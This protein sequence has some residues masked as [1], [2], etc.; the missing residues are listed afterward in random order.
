MNKP[1]SVGVTGG[2]GSG[3]T[4]VVKLFE[5]KGIS[6]YIA[7]E[8]AKK[9]ML[10]DEEL[11]QS[12]KDKFG[13]K[14]YSDGKLNKKY[15]SNIVFGDDEKL[16][17]LNNLVHPVVRNHFDLWKHRQMSPYVI[18]ESALIFEHNQQHLFD[19]IIL[20]T[21]PEKIRIER[22]KKRSGMSEKEIK[23]RIEHQIPD[24]MK[25]DYVNYNIENINI[26][27]LKKDIHSINKK[28]INNIMKK[29]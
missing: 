26:Y 23:E 22:V 19:E 27:E 4:T 15:I 5:K 8:E 7:D 28:I 13:E 17:Q 6:T 3:K 24:E 25:M 21:A 16:K 29:N 10:N 1:Y 20:V 14:S 2:I 11:I 12:I 9:L 18:Y